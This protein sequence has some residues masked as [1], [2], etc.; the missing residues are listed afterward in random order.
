MSLSAF[1]LNLFFVSLQPCDAWDNRVHQNLYSTNFSNLCLCFIW[2]VFDS[3]PHNW[4]STPDAL[5]QHRGS[6]CVSCCQVPAHAQGSHFWNQCRSVSNPGPL[7][8]ANSVLL[9]RY[10]IFGRMRQF[11]CNV[12]SLYRCWYWKGLI[13]FL[14]YMLEPI[15]LS[16]ALSVEAKLVVADR[17]RKPFSTSNLQ[18]NQ[19]VLLLCKFLLI[20]D[21]SHGIR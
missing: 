15:Y 11:H 17:C 18:K 20:S 13:V 12:I 2:Q 4:L 6:V 19:F 16:C 5:L 14:S 1:S 9:S 3:L 21:C 7:K 10:D 8:Y